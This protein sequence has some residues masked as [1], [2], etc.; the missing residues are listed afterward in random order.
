ML[1]I[2]IFSDSHGKRDRVASLMQRTSADT[3]LFL[4]DGLS[5]L[6]AIDE[7]VDVRAVR[8]NCDLFA[9]DDA[10]YSRIVQLGAYRLYL[11]HGHK[12]GVKYGI[13]AAITAALAADAD[14][15]LYGHTHRAFE[16][17]FPAGATLGGKTLD[18]PFLVLCPGALG[19][20]EASFATLTLTPHGILSH[21]ATL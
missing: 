18:R 17:T 1:N 11:T 2:V 16:R 19:E 21:I 8:G 5:D 13:D 4:G 12:E 15:L 10:P 14:G 3:V 20:R 6:D 7:R 9:H